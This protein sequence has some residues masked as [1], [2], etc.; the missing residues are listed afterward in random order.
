MFSLAGGAAA[1]AAAGRLFLLGATPLPASVVGVEGYLRANQPGTERRNRICSNTPRCAGRASD[2]ST[3][4][5]TNVD[6][7]GRVE[8]EAQKQTDGVKLAIHHRTHAIPSRATGSRSKRSATTTAGSARCGLGR[9]RAGSSSDD[10]LY[11]STG[12]IV[13]PRG[14]VDDGISERKPTTAAGR[15]HA[16]GCRYGAG[17]GKARAA[18]SLCSAT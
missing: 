17:L 8:V 2:P 9:A 6:V 16:M 10:Q 5:T 3:G 15:L 1:L 18:S 4:E 14:R 13:G 12:D 11:E 7:V